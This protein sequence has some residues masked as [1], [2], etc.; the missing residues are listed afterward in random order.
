MARLFDWTKYLSSNFGVTIHLCDGEDVQWLRSSRLRADI[1]A[2]G[3]YQPDEW[4][5]KLLIKGK[6]TGNHFKTLI[7]EFGHH[8]CHT[9]RMGYKDNPWV[10]RYFRSISKEWVLSYPQWEREEEVVVESFAR[11][12]LDWD[13]GMEVNKEFKDFLMS[14]GGPE[15]PF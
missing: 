11:W 3:F 10:R 9:G 1:D 2:N 13:E 14:L 12:A 7:H 4:A 15:P 5:I 8:L 6:P